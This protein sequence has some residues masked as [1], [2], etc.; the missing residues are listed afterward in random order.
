M[1]SKKAL[2]TL[3]VSAVA[4]SVAGA[5]SS[6]SAQNSTEKEK[7][8]GVVKAGKNDCAAAGGSHSCAAA[9][10]MDGAGDEWVALPKGACEK[11]VGG[12]LT[13][14]G[15]APAAAPAVEAAPAPVEAAPAPTPAE[16]AA[17]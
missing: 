4:L 8:Y 12:S 6:A 5:A 17:H 11:I 9:S 14:S 3:L 15:D 10:T 1:V 13:P 16:G 7:C 2:N